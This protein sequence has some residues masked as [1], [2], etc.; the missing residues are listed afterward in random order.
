MTQ[1]IKAPQFPESISEGTVLAWN[2]AVGEAAQ[3]D[4]LIVEIETDKVVLE[5]SAPTNG[6][7]TEILVEEGDTI[8][9]GDVL[10]KFDAEA[11]KAAAAAP[12]AATPATTTSAKSSSQKADIKTPQFPES[13]SEGTLLGWNKEI[14]EL[15]ERDE[16]IVEIETDKVVLEV[17]APFKGSISETL[18]E[19]GATVASGDLLGYF[20][21]A[22]AAE[23]TEAVTAAAATAPPADGSLQDNGS[24]HSSSPSAR[25]LMRE[26]GVTAGEVASSLESGQRISKADVQA[27]QEKGDLTDAIK[28]LDSVM[29]ATQSPSAGFANR[30]EKRVPMTRIR[31]RIAERLVDAQHS[32]AMLTTFNEVN[33]QPIQEM[34]SKYQDAFQKAHDVKLGYMSFFVRACVEGL[35]RFPAV[36]ASIDGDDV[37]YHG[38]YDIGVAVSTDRGLVVPIVREADKKGYAE[39]ESQIVEFGQKA[40]DNKLSIDDIIGGTFSITNGGI[41]GS[42]LSTPILNPPQTA[43]LGM[44]SIQERAV[45]VD[46]EIKILP[47]MNLALTYDHRLIDGKDAVQ[48]LA[49]VKNF[50]EDP[51]RLL[52]DI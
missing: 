36:N 1:D 24:D 18:I 44:H 5:V 33:M 11:T 12:E 25:K 31:K 7:I 4:E 47:M 8:A 26:T 48:F 50:I 37:V 41:F 17:T 10:A 43:I 2:K 13:I 52:L 45:V 30:E 42:V 29:N 35:K 27:Y 23:S 20:T 21:S 40:K 6:A 28:E 49:T 22:E 3:R 15:A 46:G 9:S 14:G 16:L 19:E 34:R 51:A 39:V 32:T 38:F